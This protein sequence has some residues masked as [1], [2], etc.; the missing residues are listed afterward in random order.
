M[1]R[2]RYGRKRGAGSGGAFRGGKYRF[3]AKR[4]YA[5]Q[6]AADISARKRKKNH[7]ATA[8]KIAVLA[9]VAGVA[10]LGYRNRETIGRKT[11]EW[12][13]AVNPW[14]KEQVRV[15]NAI[16]VAPPSQ[17]TTITPGA[18]QRA[19]AVREELAAPRPD[20]RI[21]DENDNV[22]TDAMTDKAARKVLGRA[23]ARTRG[24]KTESLQGTPGGRRRPAKA[25]PANTPK[26]D[27]WNATW[28]DD[29]LVPVGNAHR[30]TVVRQ[31]AGKAAIPGR[32]RQGPASGAMGTTDPLRALEKMRAA[33][34]RMLSGRDSPDQ[35]PLSGVPPVEFREPSSGRTRQGSRPKAPTTG[36]NKTKDAKPAGGATED[37]RHA[38]VIAGWDKLPAKEK[39]RLK[40]QAFLKGYTINSQGYVDGS[41][42]GGY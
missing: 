21:Y 9:G 8:K 31:P 17:T 11:G 6:R 24:K 23:R 29:I 4:R 16:S 38:Q 33:D 28:V 2:K 5:L 32:T 34:E 12:R 35:N 40:D 41:S 39:K 7:A 13:N 3:T 10:Y 19:Q 36:T 30:S 25:N 18:R 37:L 14:K 15:A 22:D 42:R 20:H 1:A 26:E 27:E